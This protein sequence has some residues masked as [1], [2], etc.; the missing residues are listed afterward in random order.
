[1]MLFTTKAL[2]RLI[3]AKLPVARR[4]GALSANSGAGTITQTG[5]LS[6]T[7]VLDGANPLRS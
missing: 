6:V 1:M 2:S 5:T 4:A 3:G 7:G